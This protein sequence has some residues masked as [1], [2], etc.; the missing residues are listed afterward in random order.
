ML[1]FWPLTLKNKIKAK[2]IIL[3]AIKEH[4]IPHVPGKSN[5]YEMWDSLTNLYQ[6]SNEN[7]KMVLREKLKSIKMTKTENVVTYLTKISQVRDE[8]GAFGEVVANSELVRTTLNGVPKQW[9]VFVEGIVARE[10]LP[11]W[12]RLWDDFIQE[13]TQRGY[14]KGSSS[15]CN[16]EENVAL[17]AKG[18]K[19][20]KKGSKGGN[21]KK[22]KER[23]TRAKSR[24]LHVISL[25]TM[26]DSV[27][28]RRTR[29]LQL[30]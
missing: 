14:V 16:D 15:N 12:D 1:L 28:I 24:A 17:A 26:L 20:S 10:N 18:K 2:R 19:K 27:L 30:Q 3:D 13:E 6:R 9:V 5:D 21:K 4:V 22:G 8:L 11:N 25:G 23:R 29:K 7:W